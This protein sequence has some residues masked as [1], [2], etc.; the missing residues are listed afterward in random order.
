MTDSTENKNNTDNNER[1]KAVE[2]RI[3][4]VLKALI[5]KLWRILRK[6]INRLIL[7]MVIVF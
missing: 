1:I 5:L 7:N 4:K 3:M 2:K 6:M